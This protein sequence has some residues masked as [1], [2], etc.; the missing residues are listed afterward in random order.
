MFR[1]SVHRLAGAT[2]REANPEDLGPGHGL[3]IRATARS[4][5]LVPSW[6]APR[7]GTS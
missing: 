6:K 7:A 3:S 2:E 1:S 4:S 5:S